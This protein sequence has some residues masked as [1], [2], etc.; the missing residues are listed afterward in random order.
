MTFAGARFTPIA[1]QFI[2]EPLITWM[3]LR[4]VDFSEPFFRDT[5]GRASRTRPMALS[6]V[7][8]LRALDDSPTLTPSLLIFQASRCGST[9]LSQMLASVSSNVVV[10]EASVINDVLSAALPSPE[11]EELLRLVIR[12]LGRHRP[13]GARHLVVKFTSWNVLSAPMIHRALPDTPMIWLQRAPLQIIASHARRPAGWMAWR[14]TGDPAL[15][16]LGLTVEAARAMSAAQFRLHAIEALFRAARDAG[17]DWKSVDY[18]QLPG[19][20]WDTIAPHARLSSNPAALER[21]RER[22]RFDSRSSG[23]APFRAG[24]RTDSL[25]DEERQLVATRIEPLYQAL[26]HQEPQS[27]QLAQSGEDGGDVVARG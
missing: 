20:L 15:S 16:M 13:D 21:M 27:D 19:A 8:Q 24:Q 7:E 4:G 5:I 18:A 2:P 6:G 23:G 11:K 22:A 26:G 12:A 10:S 14:E 1:M 3:D 17:L 25:S 9:L